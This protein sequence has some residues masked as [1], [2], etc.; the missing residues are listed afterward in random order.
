M[1]GTFAD[2]VLFRGRVQLLDSRLDRPERNGD[3]RS[4]LLRARRDRIARAPQEPIDDIQA[5]QVQ[6][7]KAVAAPLEQAKKLTHLSAADADIQDPG[8]LG[9]P[10]RLEH[11]ADRELVRIP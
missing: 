7:T 11:R 5:E 1:E 2:D 6:A 10:D 9:L 3:A 8:M 4:Q